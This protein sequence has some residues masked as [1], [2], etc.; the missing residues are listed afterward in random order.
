MHPERALMSPEPARNG[1]VR[2]VCALSLS[3]G[4]PSAVR[5]LTDCCST[6]ARW[7]HLTAHRM[8]WFEHP[9]GC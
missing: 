4:T 9:S 8:R 5:A 7:L 3:K 1:P 6:T 2:V